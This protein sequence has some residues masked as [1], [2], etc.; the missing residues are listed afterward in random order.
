MSLC[1]MPDQECYAMLHIQGTDKWFFPA[2]YD[3]HHF[4]VQFVVA[5]FLCMDA[6]LHT[7]ARQRMT[8]VL[9]I[10][11]NA[12]SIIGIDIVAPSRSAVEH[13]LHHMSRTPID[14]VPVMILHDVA[15]IVHLVQQIHAKH[16]QRGFRQPHLTENVLQLER[17]P[18]VSLQK[19]HQRFSQLSFIDARFHQP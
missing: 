15:C 7:V 5:V 12:Q 13:T 19:S 2:F 9:V 16:P 8:G 11:R 4:A 18:R 3:F 6:H 17:T 10:D 14:E 1:K